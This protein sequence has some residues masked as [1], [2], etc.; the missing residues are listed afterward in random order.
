[1]K[2]WSGTAFMKTAEMPAVARML[3]E[4]GFHGMLISDHLVFPKEM[5]TIY[6]GH[7]SGKMFWPADTEWP[8]AWVLV[9]AMAAVTKNLHFGN[10]VY[11]APS[12]PIIEVAKQVGT[13][14]TIAGGRVSIGLSAG[15]MREEF[16]LLG[17]DFDNRGPRLNEMIQALRELWK[18]GWVS[19]KGEYYDIPEMMIE[20]HPPEP[21]PILCGGESKA[22][23]RR[24]ARYCDG[25]VGTAYSLDD[26]EHWIQ[27]INDLRRGYGREH[28]P[29]DIIMGLRETPSLELYKQAEKIG[30]TGVMVS[31]WANWERTHSG[32]HNHLLGS[33]E[34]Y[35]APID[36]FR[37]KIIDR[38]T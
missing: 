22:A 8:D 32:D 21:V 14:A 23:L 3:D 12:R 17:Q 30:V 25:W 10:N 27:R 29:F 36:D 33:A 35:R 18:G 16:E 24:A 2:F 20:P 7:E 11:I 4:A 5:T 15:W 19:W 37:E 38:L 9:G 6:P 13:A 28:E 26:A 1:M 31:P 34:S